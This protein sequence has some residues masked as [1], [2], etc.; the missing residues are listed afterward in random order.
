MLS[1]DIRIAIGKRIRAFRVSH[2]YTQSEFSE[3]IDISVNF[4]SEI[5]NGKKGFSAETLY[6]LCRT[7]NV[8]ADYFLLNEINNCPATSI[9]DIIN[10]YSDEQLDNLVDYITSYKKLKNTK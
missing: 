1:E 8:S 4:L 9:I 2:N 7:Y 3:S 10:S 5:E 6:R